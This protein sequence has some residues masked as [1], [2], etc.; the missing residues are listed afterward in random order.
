M[1]GPEIAGPPQSK[2]EAFGS[3]T[4][5]QRILVCG[6]R[7]P[8]TTD[9]KRLKRR[10]QDVAQHLAPGSSITFINSLDPNKFDDLLVRVVGAKD[11][12]PGRELEP[13][14]SPCTKYRK[15]FELEEKYPG[16]T[17]YHVAGNAASYAD[18]SPL[19]N[20]GEG[21]R[22]N[23]AIVLGTQAVQQAGGVAKQLPPHSQDTRVLTILLQLRH[24]TKVWKEPLH[25]ITENQEDQTEK[26]AVVP[27]VKEENVAEQK[28]DVAQS[29]KSDFI[30]TQAI[31]ARALTMAL[32]YPQMQSAVGELFEEN[33]AGDP[34]PTLDLIDIKDL[35]LD[36]PNIPFAAIQ[37]VIVDRVGAFAVVLGT[38]TKEFGLG[39]APSASKTYNFAKG[40]RVCVCFRHI[41][42]A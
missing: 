33:E 12:T 9:Q 28:S 19:L 32:A 17:V 25:I 35:G 36:K 3:L 42:L 30:N 10:I 23:T 4:K 37:Q 1:G 5:P 11:T 39:L 26:L 13:E 27:K 29:H 7:P 6:W 18:L 38:Y 15:A 21:H 40:D 20:C 14:D 34:V 31:Y 22:F 16:I 24:C 8:W 41:D 2:V